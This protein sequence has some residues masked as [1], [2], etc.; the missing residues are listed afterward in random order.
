MQTLCLYHAG[1]MDGFG[2]AWVVNRYAKDCE[3][4]PVKYNDP[5]PDVASR[6]VYI[7]DFSYPRD[8]LIQMYQ[9]AN[10]LIVL[11]HHKSAQENLQGLDF[12]RFD[13]NK[14]GCIMT[15][16][17]LFPDFPSPMFLDYIQDRD[18]WKFELENSKA[19]NAAMFS[20]P[21]DFEVWS[22]T[23]IGTRSL[24]E[25]KEQGTA[26]LRDRQ[27]QIDSLVSGWA[28]S[29]ATIG[30]YDVPCLNCPRPLASD[31]LNILA[32]NEPFAAGYFDNAKNRQFELRSTDEGVDVS[33]IARQF[34]GGGHRNAAGFSVEKPNLKIG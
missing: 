16:E 19:I 17:C 8:V 22:H 11:D 2:S 6:D 4:I 14:S 24:I 12:A 34:G 23:F 27:K 20:Y 21:M 25:L 1:C 7:V 30:G 26:I 13:M 18:L 5:P 29:R 28:I 31:V 15:W 32:Q 10:S 9:D 3:F 33:Q